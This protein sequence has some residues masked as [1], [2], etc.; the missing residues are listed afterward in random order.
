MT[1]DGV[2]TKPG[3]AHYATLCGWCEWRAELAR[4]EGTPVSE[5][6]KRTTLLLL[7]RQF[8]RELP[9]S[10]KR[11]VASNPTYLSELK[12]RSKPKRSR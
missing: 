4:E 10:V 9:P 7:W 2:S 1:L 6:T 11:A 3:E 12:E 5:A 8:W